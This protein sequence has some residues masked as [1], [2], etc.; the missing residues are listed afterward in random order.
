[1]AAYEDTLPL[2]TELNGLTIQDILGKGA[3]G[4]TYLAYDKQLETRVAVKE[5][6][7]SSLASRK[8]DG[9][10][11][12]NAPSAAD[13]LEEGRESFLEEART[14]ARLSHPNIVDV[15]SYFEAN[16]TAYMVMTYYEG[17]AFH[18]WLVEHGTFDQEMLDST[19]PPLMD[20]LEFIHDRGVV[21]RDIKPANIYLTRK[22]E[23]ILLDFGAAKMAMDGATQSATRIGSAGYAALEQSS[24]RQK[25]GPWTDIYGLSASFYRMITGDIPPP[26]DERGADMM[27]GGKDP[28]TYL[29]RMDL[30]RPISSR[31]ASAIDYGMSLNARDRPQTVADWR[32]IIEGASAPEPT[33][34]R[35]F[36]PG[37]VAGPDVIEVEVEEQPWGMIVSVAAIFVLLI[38]AAGYLVVS[39][40]I[41]PGPSDPVVVDNGGSDTEPVRSSAEDAQAYAD[42]V[43]LDTL[44]AYQQFVENYPNSEYVERAQK[45][46]D[47]FDEAEWQKALN[48]N[49][50]EAYESYLEQFPTGLHAAEARAILERMDAE[51]EERAQA[52]AAQAA[53]ERALW[54]TAQEERTIEAVDAYLTP[55]PAGRFSSEARAL[56]ATLANAAADRAAWRQAEQLDTRQGYE[57]YLAG[58]PRGQF[59]PNAIEAMKRFVLTPGETIKDC[60]RCPT[61]KVLDGASFLQGAS[62]GDRFAKS[63]E[64][65]AHTVA[66]LEPFA[67]GTHEVT[68]NEYSACV[69]AGA[70]QVMPDDGGFGRGEKP[71]VNVTW[72]EATAYVN[73]L[74]R[75][76]GFAYRLPSESEWEYAAR[77]GESSSIYDGDSATIC[78]FANGAARESGVAWANKDCSDIG[79]EGALQIGQLKPNSF[80]LYD[81]LGNVA[82]FTQ[83]CLSLDYRRSP[84]DGSASETGLCS[85][86]IVR[87]GSWFSGP[88]DMRLS[89]RAKQN[90]TVRNTYT[91]IRV[92]R[93]TE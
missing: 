65:P 22:G 18:E 50:R 44:E 66:I 71:V 91:G 38:G 92:V 74:A 24:T 40:M 43:E 6:Y 76:T 34:G 59:V 16:G 28:Y 45:R 15:K 55:F 64:K 25:L 39:N 77:A 19:L 7:P 1:M 86:R 58:Y 5:Y 17:L 49:T 61:L 73:W 70:C 27:D 68:F 87:G 81:M 26:A 32:K 80:G 79:G 30:S 82:E 20:A 88:V 62:T 69:E 12:P 89:A 54:Q 42:A 85:A 83:D 48:R 75:E 2:G 93:G 8:Q 3:F 21:H 31:F 57:A 37:A 52:A 47:E 41:G 11:S 29:Q 67:I 46:I 35:A 10:I 53:R 60:A 63:N 78:Q 90:T 33:Y 13:P 84:T 14:V 36:D 4:I 23:P 56:R 72:I 51:D 9:S